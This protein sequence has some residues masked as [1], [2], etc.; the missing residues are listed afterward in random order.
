MTKILVID[1]E[2][3]GLYDFK[4][5]PWDQKQPDLVEIA[6]AVFDLRRLVWAK[7]CVLITP[8]KIEPEAAEV[9]GLTLNHLKTYGEKTE[10]ALGTFAYL[11]Q[12]TDLL[13][14]HNISFDLA[15]IRAA[16][17]SRQLKSP[18]KGCETYC[19]MRRA[20]DILQLPAKGPGKYKWP[21]L[22]EAYVR[23]VGADYPPGAHSALNDALA[24][25]AVYF[26]LEDIALGV[27]SYVPT[28][29]PLENPTFPTLPE[30]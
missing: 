28:D 15:C 1:V 5:K 25:A 29:N 6:F 17:A 19:T 22:E 23:L 14:G 9:H 12:K 26:E 27:R 20:T 30:L 3:T 18:A 24:T 8:K 10:K 2:T 4:R 16:A 21:T 7:S 13:V 11:L